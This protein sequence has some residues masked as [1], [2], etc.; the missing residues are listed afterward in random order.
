MDLR[1]EGGIRVDKARGASVQR[2]A[3]ALRAVD[4]TSVAATSGPW[5]RAMTCTLASLALDRAG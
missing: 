2:A 5:C 1:D 4:P 3:G